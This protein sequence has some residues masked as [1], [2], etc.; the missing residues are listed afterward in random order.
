MTDLTIRALLTLP[1]EFVPHEILSLMHYPAAPNTKAVSSHFNRLEL[2]FEAPAAPLAGKG[3]AAAAPVVTTTI[4]SPL[5]WSQLV[6]RI[7][8]IPAPKIAHKPTSS[9]IPDA[10]SV[11]KTR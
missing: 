1:S 9:A 5:Q 3:R 10:K 11:N 2:V 6:A 8:A 4:L 7:G